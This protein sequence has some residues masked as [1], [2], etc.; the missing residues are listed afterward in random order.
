MPLQKHRGT[1]KLQLHF[2]V[3]CIVAPLARCA[4]ETGS[5]C[6][7]ACWKRQLRDFRSFMARCVKIFAER[8]GLAQTRSSLLLIAAYACGYAQ[9]SRLRC[10]RRETMVV[11]SEF[12]AMAHVPEAG[13]K[14]HLNQKR[15]TGKNK[16]KIPVL[17]ASSRIVEY[18]A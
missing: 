5:C 3:N 18:R 1:F 12:A 17:Y 4:R 16:D 9:R 2:V 15:K 7:D 11:R 8:G 13:Y 6:K 10:A 14:R